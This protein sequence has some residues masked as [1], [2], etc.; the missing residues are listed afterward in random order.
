MA[1]IH[2]GYLSRMQI[3]HRH[4]THESSVYHYIAQF[5]DF[6]ASNV[7][8][9]EGMKRAVLTYPE[10]EIDAWF[11]KHAAQLKLKRRIDADLT[12]AFLSGR[13]NQYEWHD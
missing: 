10:K 13:I 12:R 5:P 4:N 1:E 9:V 8:R 7:Q 2:S 11:K 6:P 3:A